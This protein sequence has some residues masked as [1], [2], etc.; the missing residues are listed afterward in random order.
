M[1]GTGTAGTDTAVDAIAALQRTLGLL[2]ERPFLIV[3]D[4]DGTLSRIVLDPWGA[5]I[6]PGAQRALRRLAGA[7]GVHVALLSGRLARDLAARAR[8]G[9]ATYVGNFGMERGSLRPGGRAGDL[10]VEV[11]PVADAHVAL[12][13]RLALE[14]PRLVGAAWLVVEHKP[15]SVAFHFRAAP[16]LDAA[17][18]QVRAAVDAI[19]PHEQLVRSAGKRVLELRPRDA[20]AKG[21]AFRS[22]LAEHR[23]RAALMLGDDVS[24][25]PA[26]LALREARAAGSI[27]GLAIGVRARDDVPAVVAAAVDLVLD[28]PAEVARYLSG[29]SARLAPGVARAPGR[30]S[31]PGQRR[32]GSYS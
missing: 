5:S 13:D 15:A 19:D 28:S 32:D 18:A 22:L 16:D 14:V 29:L 9:G 4:F 25:V 12:A 23:P 3:S 27:A 24:D 8:V 31:A 26:F 2:G 6:I 7:D 1:K 21:D 10:R 20:P 11:V 17:A 30:A